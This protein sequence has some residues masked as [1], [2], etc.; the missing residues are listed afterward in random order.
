[1][2]KAPE[3]IMSRK[4]LMSETLS[5]VESVNSSAEMQAALAR[6]QEFAQRQGLM[7]GRAFEGFNFGAMPGQASEIGNASFPALPEGLH[8][9]TRTAYPRLTDPAAFEVGKPAYKRA[10]ERRAPDEPAP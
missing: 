5:S 8:L 9:D 6:Q 1:M 2:E 4:K 7:T 10:L 3:L